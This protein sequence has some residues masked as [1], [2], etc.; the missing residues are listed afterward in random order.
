M[1]LI[2]RIGRATET[3]SDPEHVGKLGPHCAPGH[4]ERGQQLAGEG[5]AAVHCGIP[6]ATGRPGC[7]PPLP[8]GAAEHDGERADETG[9]EW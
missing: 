8:R 3:D 6:N 4:Q 1:Q 9:R 7:R 2:R 5:N